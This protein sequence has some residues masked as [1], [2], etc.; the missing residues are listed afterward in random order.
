MGGEQTTSDS[1]ASMT[2]STSVLTF[3]PPSRHPSRERM[4]EKLPMC[5]DRSDSSKTGRDASSDE[6]D[7]FFCDERAGDEARYSQ[8]KPQHR[9][10]QKTRTF[11][12]DLGEL[13]E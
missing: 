7:A 1:H 11:V 10:M 9:Q 6:A 13:E 4:T 12:E 5:A 8:L 3:L 2:E